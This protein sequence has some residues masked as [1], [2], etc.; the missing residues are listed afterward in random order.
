MIEVHL[1]T[2]G[3]EVDAAGLTR[4]AEVA[5]EHRDVEIAEISVTLLDDAAIRELN[6]RHL[7]H[8]RVTDVISFALG[9]EGGAGLVGDV[10]VGA[11]QAARQAADAGIDCHE[12]LVRLVVHGVLHVT[13]MDHPEG[14]EERAGSEMYRLQERL[15]GQLIRQASAGSTPPAPGSE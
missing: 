13:G 5:L 6:A 14:A 11:G 9:Q 4:A 7:G 1:E 15:V 10:Y 12:E 8:D 3:R 2:G